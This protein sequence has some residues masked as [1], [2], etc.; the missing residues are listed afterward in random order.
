MTTRIAVMMLAAFFLCLAAA[1]RA[2]AQ[3]VADPIPLLNGTERAKL[4]FSIPFVHSDVNVA[5]CVSCSDTSKNDSGTGEYWAV[6]FIDN[7]TAA[8]DLT[9][10][11]GV[12]FVDWGGDTDIMCTRSP[13]SIGA[14]TAGVGAQ[15]IF[16]GSA[17]VVATTK[18][19]MCTAFMVPV[20]GDPPGFMTMLPMYRTSKQKGGM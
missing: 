17:R 3:S 20:L 13:A 7:G 8:N 5:T 18:T 6:E 10:G 19:L 1:P 16:E 9:L 2:S 12:V 14:M 15:D 4:L 11:D